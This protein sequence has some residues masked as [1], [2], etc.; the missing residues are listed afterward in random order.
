MQKGD[1]V[2]M[3]KQTKEQRLHP[4][5]L[6]T[7][8]NCFYCEKEILGLPVCDKCREKYT[9]GYQQAKEEDKSKFALK[10]F[11]KTVERWKHPR[12][13]DD[14]LS[15]K[16]LIDSFFKLAYQQAQ[17][18]IL[19]LI[20]EETI[21]LHSIFGEKDKILFIKRL[22]QKIKGDEIK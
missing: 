16:E 10:L 15:T 9:F 3:K 18:D 12:K 1:I 13:G 5:N 2:K 14:I 7:K 19:K 21:I 22:K 17:D 8:R 20:D 11:N 6:P 4:C